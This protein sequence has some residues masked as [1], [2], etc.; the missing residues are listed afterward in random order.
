[1]HI[2]GSLNTTANTMT[3][4]ADIPQFKYSQYDFSDVQ[5]KGSGDLEK[6]ELTGSVANAQIGDSVFFPETT[7][8]ISAQNDIS[9]L[10]VNTTS[11]QAINKANLSAQIR[12]FSDGASIVFKPSSFVLNNKTWSLEQ[13]GELSFRRNAVAQGSVIFRESN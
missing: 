1:S 7:F 6:L 12:T 2:T 10:T 11:N 5:L 4:D 3:V 8:S 9:D 13:G